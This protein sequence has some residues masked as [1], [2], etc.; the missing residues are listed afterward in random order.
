MDCFAFRTR[1]ALRQ[2]AM[3][4]VPA[5]CADKL[6]SNGVIVVMSLYPSLQPKNGWPSFIAGR[7]LSVK[8]QMTASSA[9]YKDFFDASTIVCQRTNVILRY[10][11]FRKT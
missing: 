11:H 2:A 10:S 4:A 6:H 1:F 7:C 9:G 3:L 5:A 8:L